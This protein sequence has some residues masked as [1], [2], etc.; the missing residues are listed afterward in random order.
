[1]VYMLSK[2]ELLNY[3]ERECE[4]ITGERDFNK[5]DQK[6]LVHVVIRLMMKAMNEQQ[7]TAKIANIVHDLIRDEMRYS[8]Y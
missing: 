1:M 8:D 4:E 7:D 5:L 3:A 6:Q 2:E